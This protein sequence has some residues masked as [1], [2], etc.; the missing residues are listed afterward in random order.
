MPEELTCARCHW[1]LYLKQMVG[2][3]GGRKGSTTGCEA[4]ISK[5]SL[6]GEIKGAVVVT[7][8]HLD[9]PLLSQLAVMT[10]LSKSER[11]R[12]CGRLMPPCREHSVSWPLRVNADICSYPIK[13]LMLWS[14]C[15]SHVLYCPMPFPN[16]LYC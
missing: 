6:I 11:Q 3:K 7:W 14:C 5:V 4:R 13:L 16:F 1:L 8:F 12:T 9:Q 15:R 2:R 10:N